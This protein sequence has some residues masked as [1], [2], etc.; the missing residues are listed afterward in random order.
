MLVYTQ[1]RLDAQCHN[2]QTCHYI[3]T[4]SS[5]AGVSS[6]HNQQCTASKHSSLAVDAQTNV[7]LCKIVM[8]RINRLQS[9]CIM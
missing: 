7:V 2:T 1:A 3:M 4:E 5:D 9:A 8:Y 6:T